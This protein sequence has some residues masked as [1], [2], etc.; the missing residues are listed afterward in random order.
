MSGGMHP[1]FDWSTEKNK[2]YGMMVSA[3]KLPD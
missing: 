1:F 3:V 2:V